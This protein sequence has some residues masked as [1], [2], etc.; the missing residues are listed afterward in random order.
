M[1][2]RGERI[3]ISTAIGLAVGVVA[4]YFFGA[5][6][7]YVLVSWFRPLE[8][9]VNALFKVFDSPFHVGGAFGAMIGALS[10]LIKG[11]VRTRPPKRAA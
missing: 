11:I 5:T 6:V 9:L 3:A 8:T 2:S 10:G 4:G 7:L 1:R